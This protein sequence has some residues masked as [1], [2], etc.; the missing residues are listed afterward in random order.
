VPD[1]EP[2]PAELDAAVVQFTANL[3]EA[4]RR[5]G[6]TQEAVALASGVP[7]AHYSRIETGKRDPGVRTLIR[8]AAALRTT[9]AELLADVKDR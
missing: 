2:E 6:M 5:A 4:R 1:D 3:R 8:I 9:A 7:Q